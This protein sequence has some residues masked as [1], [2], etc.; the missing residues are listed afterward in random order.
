MAMLVAIPMC[1]VSNMQT[2]SSGFGSSWHLQL[3]EALRDGR[4]ISL[5]KP[6]TKT[7]PWSVGDGTGI[8]FR[9]LGGNYREIYENVEQ[10]YLCIF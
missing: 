3:A 1:Q 10:I 7:A 9:I 4:R 2:V 8:L 5:W 6:H